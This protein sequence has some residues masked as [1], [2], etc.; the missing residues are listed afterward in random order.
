[1]SSPRHARPGTRR[2]QEPRKLPAT[3]LEVTVEG[4]AWGGKAVG[5]HEGKVVFVSKAVPGDKL[6]AKV[7]RGKASYAE[8]TSVSVLRPSPDRVEPRCKFFSHCGGCPWLAAAHPRQLREKETLVA[9]ALRHHLEGAELLP[10]VGAEPFLG[11]RHRGEF[12]VRPTGDSV[13]IGFFQEGSHR[14]VNLDLCL[15]FDRAYNLRYQALRAALKREP[16]ARALEQ[17]TL[18][19]ADDGETYALHFRLHHGGPREAVRL[20]EAADGLGFAGALATPAGD[21]GRVMASSGRPWTTY[22]LPGG[23]T[24]AG[25][26]FLLRADV[27][28]FTQAHYAMN[29]RLVRAVLD[30]LAPAQSERVL[31]LYAGGGNFTLPLAAR[32]NEVVAVEGSPFASEDAREN[33]RSA[34]ARNVRHVFGEAATETAGLLAR[35][36]RFDAVLLDPPRSGAK[37]ALGP[38]SRLSP[39]RILYVSC[40]LPAL[41]RDL[42]FLRDHGYRAVRIQPW[43]LFPQ[44]YGV[45]TMALLRK[46]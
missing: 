33:A 20:C 8:A 27:R 19:R 26:D 14:V 42:T 17:V 10:I 46:E 36:A 13:K 38:L 2:P 18:D 3:L 29:R 32:C 7:T 25:R 28:S 16:A 37:E 41:E 34:S 45:E 23:E 24:G 11:Y 4:Y 12:H 35:G 43:D 9:Q 5:R 22:A 15:L 6:L 40:N 30:W 39:P 1:M 31:D 21:D 44:T